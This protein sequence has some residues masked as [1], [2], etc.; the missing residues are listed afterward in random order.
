MQKK[1]FK[2]GVL[3]DIHRQQTGTIFCMKQDTDRWISTPEFTDAWLISEFWKY[4]AH[5]DTLLQQR[6]KILPEEPLQNKSIWHSASVVPRELLRLQYY[7]A[8][9][10]DDVLQV[11]QAIAKAAGFS[12]IAINET[13]RQ[14]PVHIPQLSSD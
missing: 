11:R 6:Q 1:K 14:R 7:P 12:W 4:D 3:C 8:L 5:M 9:G 13:L 10:G 2:L